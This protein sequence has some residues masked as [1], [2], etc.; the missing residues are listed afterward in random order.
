MYGG[1]FR[2]LALRVQLEEIVLNVTGGRVFPLVGLIG[3]VRCALPL[4]DGVVM[5]TFGLITLAGNGTP[6]AVS[7]Y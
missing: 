1:T 4:D 3:I 2:G 6:R 7:S 5:T